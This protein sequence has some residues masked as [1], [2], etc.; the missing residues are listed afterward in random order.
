MF[1]FF[2]IS[3]AE[4]VGLFSLISTRMGFKPASITANSVEQYVIAG[5]ITSDPFGKFKDFI[6]MYK[7]SVPL[8]QPTANL[9]L[10]YFAKFFSKILTSF[11]KIKFVFLITFF[12]SFKIK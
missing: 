3:S 12:I 6:A 4:I 7:A 5:R 10:Q 9:E 11:P 8:P 2:L 1:I